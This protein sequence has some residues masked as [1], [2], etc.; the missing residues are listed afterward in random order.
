VQQRSIEKKWIQA[1]QSSFKKNF[2]VIEV[3]SWASHA[4]IS[5]IVYTTRH[6]TMRSIFDRMRITPSCRG[7]LGVGRPT[8]L[9]P[10]LHAAFQKARIHAAC[11]QR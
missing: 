1:S 4:G 8:G 11:T 9:L 2:Y 10:G 7:F 3:A 6:M 5:C